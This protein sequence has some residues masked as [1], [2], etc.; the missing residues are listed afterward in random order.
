MNS[1]DV[2]LNFTETTLRILVALLFVAIT[3]LNVASPVSSSCDSPDESSFAHSYQSCETHADTSDPEHSSKHDVVH[4]C[5]L[6]HCSFLLVLNSYLPSHD[7]VS[8]YFQPNN[9][10]VVSDYVSLLLRPPIA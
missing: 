3:V 9:V 5:H 4:S 6:G 2:P 1:E 8:N 7:V 10:L